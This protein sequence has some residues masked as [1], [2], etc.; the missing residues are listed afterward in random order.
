MPKKELALLTDVELE[1][2]NILW[3]LEKATV[4]EVSSHIA[5][6]RNLAY[7][8]VAT[9]MKILEQKKYLQCK[10]DS[11][12]HTFTPLVSK[13]TYEAN[14]LNHLVTNLFDNEPV[15]LVQRLLEAKKLSKDEV[16][17]IEDSLK[18]LGSKK[19]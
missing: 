18:L 2:M 1:L 3:S 14:C 16:Q 6:E 13:N 15:A 11:F 4:K 5:K 12:A 17:A 9:V 7:T 10:K 8:T 19:K